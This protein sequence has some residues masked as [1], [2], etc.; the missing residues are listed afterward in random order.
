[1]PT[2]AAHLNDIIPSQAIVRCIERY[3]ASTGSTSSVMYADEAFPIFHRNQFGSKKQYEGTVIDNSNADK[4][5]IKFKKSF[6]AQYETLAE[7]FA[8]VN[9][10]AADEK[11]S[12]SL[13]S[14]LSTN[15]DVISME[16]TH[17]QS[18][19]FTIKKSDY[20]F[21]I[22]HFLY[23]IDEDDDEAILTAFKG[24]EK[25]PSYAGSLSQT[26][27]ELSS[28]LEPDSLF[29]FHLSLNEVSI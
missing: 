15:P 29:N 10:I 24:N 8:D 12:L 9:F 28:I 11:L 14:I 27:S 5:F 22:Q 17:E 26:I 18:A 19:F 21:F 1:M 20:T 2:P 7:Y 23:E 13:S 6:K 16:L 4:E 3:Y 25:L